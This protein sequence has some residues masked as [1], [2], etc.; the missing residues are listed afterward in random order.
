MQ[1]GS[2][3]KDGYTKSDEFSEK[4]QGGGVLFN[5]EICV[6]DFGNFKKAFSS[7]GALFQKGSNDQYLILYLA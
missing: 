4:F 2:I 3:C 5:P 7:M 6:A 1:C